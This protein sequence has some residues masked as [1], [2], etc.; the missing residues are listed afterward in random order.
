MIW[1]VHAALMV[2]HSVLTQR[3]PLSGDSRVTS[4]A[5]GDAPHALLPCFTGYCTYDNPTGLLLTTSR[6]SIK[7]RAQTIRT[8]EEHRSGPAG[9][10]AVAGQPLPD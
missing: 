5:P 1:L 3:F 8:P 10:R 7:R 4:R 6:G 2:E 9:A